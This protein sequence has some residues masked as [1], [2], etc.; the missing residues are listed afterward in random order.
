MAYPKIKGEI[1][2]KNIGPKRAQSNKSLSFKEAP[3]HSEIETEVSAMKIVQI[4]MKN[5]LEMI[6][7]SLVPCTISSTKNCSLQMEK[8][9]VKL[10]KI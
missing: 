8:L 4:E 2:S 9:K 7:D 1:V 5:E 3:E 6:I 10:N